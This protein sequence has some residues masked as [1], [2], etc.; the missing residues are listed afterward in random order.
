MPVDVGAM[1]REGR[2]SDLKGVRSMIAEVLEVKLPGPIPD[3]PSP[4]VQKMGDEAAHAPGSEQLLQFLDRST[5]EGLVIHLWKDQ[6]GYDAFAARREELTAQ[7]KERG[8]NIVSRRTYEVTYR[9]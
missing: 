8:A 9:S 1:L 6:E 2:S 7:A 4:E 5:G 3:S